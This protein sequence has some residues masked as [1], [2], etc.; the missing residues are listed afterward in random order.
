M[1]YE[2]IHWTKMEGRHFMGTESQAFPPILAVTSEGLEI[3]AYI[4]GRAWLLVPQKCLSSVQW[5]FSKVTYL[6]SA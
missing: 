6:E 4:G 3:T 2:K 1:T 5:I